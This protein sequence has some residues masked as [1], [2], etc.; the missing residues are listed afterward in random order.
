MQRWVVDREDGVV[1]VL[2]AD[3]LGAWIR[4]KQMMEQTDE[5]P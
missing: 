5:V 4:A 2:A 3:E 1:F